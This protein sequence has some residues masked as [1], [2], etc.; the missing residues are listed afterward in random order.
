MHDTSHAAFFRP[1]LFALL[2]SAL[3]GACQSG[4]PPA[5]SA[6]EADTLAVVHGWTTDAV[7]DTTGAPGNVRMEAVAVT[8]QDSFDRVVFGFQGAALPAYSI[9][10]PDPPLRQCGSGRPVELAGQAVLEVQFDGAVA[11]TE[12]GKSSVENRELTASYPAIQSGRLICDFEGRVVWGFGLA[13]KAAYRVR[14]DTTAGQIVLD[15]RR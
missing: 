15:V 9:R 2:V 10:Y 6:D 14:K 11:H 7:K 3:I 5:P 13:T 1:L 4:N 8:A 12:T